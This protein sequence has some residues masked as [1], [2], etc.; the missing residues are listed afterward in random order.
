MMVANE[1]PV[2]LVAALAPRLMPQ[3]TEWLPPKLYDQGRVTDFTITTDDPNWMHKP[4]AKVKGVGGP[5]MP[6][7][8]QLSIV[9][10]LLPG[11][12]E[13]VFSGYDILFRQVQQFR[14]KR[15]FPIGKAM[16]LRYRIAALGCDVGGQLYAVIE[17]DVRIAPPDQK[18]CASG[19]L[20]FYINEPV[21]DVKQAAE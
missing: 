2:N 1:L 18:V 14:T 5:I 19:I 11:G 21:E 9:N 7:L 6:A 13:S 8:M 10:A 12:I 20:E 15:A 17:F 3:P 4:N 16:Q